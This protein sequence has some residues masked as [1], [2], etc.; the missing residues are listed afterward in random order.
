MNT[1][2]KFPLL[3]G[4]KLNK[5]KCEIA[6]IG[7]LKGISL[8]FCGMDFIKI[9]IKKIKIKIKKNKNFGNTFLL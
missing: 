5:V 9:T 4:L 2:H 3:S 6:D 8:A 1:F 7:I